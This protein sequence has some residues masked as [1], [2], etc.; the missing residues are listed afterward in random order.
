MASEEKLNVGYI[1]DP[2]AR[3]VNMTQERNWDDRFLYWWMP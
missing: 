2:I 3:P 1:S